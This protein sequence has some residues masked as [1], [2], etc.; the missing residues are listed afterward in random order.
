[1]ARIGIIGTGWGARAQAPAFDRAGLDVVAISGRNPE[2]TEGVA[3]ELGIE[4]AVTDWRTLIDSS[5]IDLV[6]VVTP[7]SHHLEMATAALDAGKHVLCE[8][9]TAL[10]ADQAR[11]LVE[12]ARRHPDRIALIDHEL[13][14]LPSFRV[15]KSRLSEIGAIRFAEARYA[16]PS[17]RDPTRPWNWW[18][19]ADEGGGVWG[20]VGSHIVD[21]FRWLIGEIVA[22]RASL[23]TI[24]RERPIPDGTMRDVTADDFAAVNL[25]FDN[26]AVAVMV[27]TVVAGVDEPTTLTLHGE[28]GSI[29]L[30]RD[31]MFFAAPREDWREVVEG[32]TPPLPGD[33]EGGFF[34][35]ATFHLGRAL[36]EALDEGKSE[37]LAFAATFDDGH[38]QQ[39]VLD[40]PRRS[41]AQDGSWES[42]PP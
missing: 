18:S 34:G 3:Q 42:V 32:E 19:S 8:K 24:I 27:L 5:E 28:H 23:E 9:P 22:V 14:F 12:A 1:M 29:R 11:M 6:S 37:A 30:V 31:Q 17:R 2:K 26:G 33:S 20:A 13:R 4:R 21:S 40:A 38:R 7:P 16:S 10:D 39:Q 25:R 15:A 41:S 36:R 35:T